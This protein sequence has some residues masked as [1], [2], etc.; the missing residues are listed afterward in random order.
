MRLVSNRIIEIKIAYKNIL[1]RPIRNIFTTISII[2]G[3]GIFFSVNI[4]T[5]SLDYSLQQY[6]DPSL[7]G[8]INHWIY[9]FRG[10]LMVFSAISLIICV[11]IIKN[12]MEMSKEDQIYEL[13]LLRAIGNSKFSIFSIL[14]N[15]ILVITII[16]MFLGLFFGSSISSLFFGPLKE[17]LGDLTSLDTNFEVI[18]HINPITYFI[19]IV[20]GLFIP[21]LFGVMPSI[22]AARANILVSLKPYSQ[23]EN[24]KFR[25]AFFRILEMILICI[26]IVV[27]IILINIGFSG[28]L[29]FTSDPTTEANISIFLLF[30]S[31]LLFILGAILFGAFFLPQI[32]FFISYILQP[33]LRKMRKICYRNLTRNL[34]RSKNSYIIISLGLAFFIALMIT[35]SSVNAG[36]IPGA[37]MRLGGDIRLGMFYNNYQTRIPLNTSK[38][39]MK[40]SHVTEVCEVKNSHWGVNNTKCDQFGSQE[41]QGVVLFVI[42]TTSYAKMHSSNSIS[43]YDSD[44]PFSDFIHQLDANGSI[45]LQKGLSQRIE[46]SVGENVSLEIK[47]I[48]NFFP[49]IRANLTIMGL[50]DILPGLQM[51]YDDVF[52]NIQEYVAIISWNTYFY[53]SNT[54]IEETTGY[55]WISCDNKDNVNDVFEDIRTFYNDSGYPWN[56]VNFDNSWE[57]RTILDESNQIEG[58]INLILIIFYGILIIGL[59]ISLLGMIISMVMNVN[60]RRNEIGVFRAIGISKLQ[61]VQLISGETLIIGL[62]ASVTGIICWIITGYLISLAPFI[63]YVPIIFTINWIEILYISI[64][65]IALNILGSF[66][67][68][69]KANKLNIIDTIRK[70]G[71]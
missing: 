11:L 64:F 56:S 47:N 32:S 48:Y 66:I 65:I 69:A 30:F 28:L 60:H 49:E 40:I 44:L 46:K 68:A 13:G 16:G 2:L 71:E 36:L 22:S 25:S 34:R 59:V 7:Y 45:F 20:A 27:G 54:T 42:N 19:S 39:I 9:L 67:P 58:I 70:R 31:Q 12:L 21:L 6:I 41:G 43:Y 5:D 62:S 37:R 4:A 52:N 10:I 23:E 26:L 57:F 61:I 53:L 29:S 1:K 3:V 55:F 18:I 14:F 50:I 24:R 38:D 15:Q 63:A 35:F 51:T 33:F 17:V 8:N